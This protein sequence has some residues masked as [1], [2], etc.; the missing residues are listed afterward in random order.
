MIE[1]DLKKKINKTV[2]DY[3][4]VVGGIMQLDELNR[5]LKRTISF[6]KPKQIII[7]IERDNHYKGYYTTIYLTCKDFEK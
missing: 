2:D 7:T 5:E 3:V 1:F 6:K 4:D